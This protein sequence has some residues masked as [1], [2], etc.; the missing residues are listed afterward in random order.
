VLLNGFEKQGFEGLK[1][2]SRA[3]L[4]NDKKSMVYY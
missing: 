1:E 3:V 4:K 2:Q